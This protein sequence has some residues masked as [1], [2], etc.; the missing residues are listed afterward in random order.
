MT[1]LILTG[2]WTRRILAD[3]IDVAHDVQLS[4][5]FHALGEVL[6]R[7]AKIGG[8]FYANGGVFQADSGNSL[9][10]DRIH[11]NGSMFLSRSEKPE[12]RST[13]KGEVGLAG[14]FI[15][16]NL[17]CD[18]GTFDN[19][20]DS[21]TPHKFAIKADRL[22]T[23]G[24]VFLRYGF[25]AT[26]EVHLINAKLGLLDCT[27]STFN[28]QGPF[29]LNAE[30]ATIQGGAVFDKCN[31]LSG[32]TLLS[33]IDVRDVSC[34]SCKF[35]LLDLC[36]ARIHRKLWWKEIVGPRQTVLDLRDASVGS[37]EDDEASWP[38]PGNIH[39]DG[40]KYERFTESP[41]S[42]TH[43]PTDVKARLRWIR[44][45]KA[46][47]PQQY[48][49][50]ALVYA[51]MGE[52]KYVREV[53]YQ[54]EELLQGRQRGSSWIRNLVWSL[55]RPFPKWTT[56]YGY[57]L[58]M[59]FW[60]MVSLT[61]LGG[62]F[63]YVGYAYKVIVPTD[64]D[65]YVNFVKQGQAPDSYP[66]FNFIIFTIEH[67]VPAINL[68]VSSAWSPNT[69]GQLPGLPCYARYL[70]WWFFFQTLAGWTLSIFFVTGLT[71]FVKS[72]K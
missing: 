41:E 72:D 30:S 46:N 33:G 15:G 36:H 35:V 10:C 60:W 61:V 8:G 58:W 64:K 28:G 40:L 12:Y 37:I 9:G 44:L 47:P 2:S 24:S 51:E 50:L 18:G 14:A 4:R 59:T 39:T 56:G 5:G 68:G 1:S 67:S 38:G 65:A 45:D 49:Q 16:S 66:E 31:T 23:V 3:G 34:R 70:R 42:V 22:T 48:R 7:D 29:A 17:E 6:F 13:F 32:V 55:W 20:G 69:V 54:L 27:E 25:S 62:L 21:A 19:P 63:A 53:R 26:G 71:G 43:C 57:K 11:V 52:T